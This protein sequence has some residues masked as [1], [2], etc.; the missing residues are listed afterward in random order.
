MMK[1]LCAIFPPTYS[2]FLTGDF[3]LL[4]LGLRLH[5]FHFVEAGDDVVG[6]VAFSDDLAES[7]VADLT[8]QF[9]E[10]VAEV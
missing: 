7:L 1:Q 10:K 3:E 4:T 9:V 2:P 6:E 5:L 8:P